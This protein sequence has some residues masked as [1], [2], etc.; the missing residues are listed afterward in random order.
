MT[1][2]TISAIAAVPLSFVTWALGGI[3]LPIKILF[4]F[5]L[6][7]IFTGL[8]KGICNKN[9]SSKVMSKGIIKKMYEL[10]II[11]VAVQLDALTGM[12]GVFRTL[13]CYYYIACE[14]LSIVENIGEYVN[15]PTTIKQYLDK[16]KSENDDAEV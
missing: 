4:M 12:D 11:V 16:L 3:D 1:V 14:G 5:I 9:L 2:K 15:Y 13:A 7:D 8:I 10:I 6:L